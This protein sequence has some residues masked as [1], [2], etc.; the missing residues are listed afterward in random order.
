MPT[1]WN[2]AW[3]Q[4]YAQNSVF[5]TEDDPAAKYTFKGDTINRT[6]GNAD[7]SAAIKGLLTPGLVPDIARQSAEVAGGR[8]VGGSPAGASTAVRMSEQNWLQRLALGNQLLSGEADRTLPYQITPYQASVLDLQRKQLE[9]QRQLGNKQNERGLGGLGGGGGHGS[10][11]YYPFA[12]GSRAGPFDQGWGSGT[13]NWGQGPTDS[14]PLGG[15]GNNW[16]L[17][18]AYDWLGFGDFGSQPGDQS[19]G[20]ISNW[21]WDFL[22]D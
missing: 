10:A 19:G 21:D 18:D 14:G 4:P 5:N 15:G 22:A 2:N 6:A 9:L 16:T 13:N 20:D 7:V 12:G 3:N 11:P 17:D 8:G 1:G